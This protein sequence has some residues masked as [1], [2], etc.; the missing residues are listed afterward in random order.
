MIHVIATIEVVEGARDAFLNEF[1]RLMPKVHAEE[2]CIEYGPAV[3]VAAGIAVQSPLR[4]GTVVVLEKWSDVG[5]LKKH[6][7]APHMAD[8]R[9][10][11]KTFVRSVQL[12]ILEPAA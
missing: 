12:Q 2:G 5:A 7:A 10:R 9:E 4:P 11:V 1:R 3:D 6:L 8:Y